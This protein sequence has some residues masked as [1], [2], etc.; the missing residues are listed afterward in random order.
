MLFRKFELNQEFSKRYA[1]LCYKQL[2]VMS[3][4]RKAH[5]DPAV[6]IARNE[7][8]SQQVLVSGHTMTGTFRTD[9]ESANF[10]TTGID[11]I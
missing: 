9:F 10:L 7:P 8:T 2:K 4:C 3:T 6:D 11:R 1:L 5:R